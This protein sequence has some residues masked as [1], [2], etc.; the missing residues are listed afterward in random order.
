MIINI[1]DYYGIYNDIKQVEL[2]P[3]ITF[4]AGCNGA[5]KSTFIKEVVETFKQQKLTYQLLDC[6]KDFHVQD[7]DSLSKR[8]SIEDL[9]KGAF[10]SEHEHYENMFMSW[11][12]NCRY[13]DNY[14]GQEVGIF[15][16]GLDSGGDV[17]FYK[18]HMGLFKLMEE[19]CRSRGIILYLIVS[20]NNFYYLSHG[21][22]TNVRTLF[23][24]QFKE[25]EHPVYKADEFEIY[26]QTIIDCA[27]A[28]GFKL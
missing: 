27:K 6:N 13:G 12:S 16:D 8:Y 23:L 26:V 11:V 18:N 4:V 24:P 1:K 5:G 3:G 9:V 21:C 14:R 20:C 10:A 7:A 2:K 15:I 25:Y 19:D 22:G 17:I 28:R